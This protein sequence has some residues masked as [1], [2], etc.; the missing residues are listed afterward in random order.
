MY[1]EGKK[2]LLAIRRQALI[3]PSIL[4]GRWQLKTEI[5]RNEESDDC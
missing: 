1:E 3:S 2:S 5:N 4:I